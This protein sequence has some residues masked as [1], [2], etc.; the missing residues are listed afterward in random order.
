MVDH[1]NKNSITV[2]ATETSA[3]NAYGVN[4]EGNGVWVYNAGNVAVHVKSGGST[5]AATTTDNVIPA[6][7]ARTLRRDPNDTHLAI[8]TASGTATVYFH[9]TTI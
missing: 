1:V 2:A 3:A 9:G 6:G 4:G 8:R 5:V 7:Q